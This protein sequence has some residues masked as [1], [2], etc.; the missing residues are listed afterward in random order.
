VPVSCTGA[1]SVLLPRLESTK[2]AVGCKWLELWRL[3]LFRIF[4]Y[5]S[6]AK[7]KKFN[8]IRPAF[9]CFATPA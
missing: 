6:L 8:Y 2:E 7:S 9:M 1:F 4:T 3:Q 5:L